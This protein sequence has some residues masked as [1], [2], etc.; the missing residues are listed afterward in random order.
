MYLTRSITDFG[1]QSF[2]MAGVIP[3]R[4]RMHK[5]LQAVGY[6]EA[7]ALRDTVICPA[8]TVLRG[9]EFHFSSMIPDVTIH[10]VGVSDAADGPED[11][12]SAFSIERKR[13]GA[14]CP[15]GYAK[16]DVLASYLHLNLMGAPDAANHFLRR[17]AAFRARNG[18]TA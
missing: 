15:G 16:G 7:T 1:G 13:T 2:E 8:G 6:V 4:C 9:H 11:F 12:P 10:N 5:R 3:A 17:C 14:T 18:A